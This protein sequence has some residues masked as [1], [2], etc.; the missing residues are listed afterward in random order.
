MGLRYLSVQTLLALMGVA[1]AVLALLP[2]AAA[3]I[4]IA[5]PPIA[6]LISRPGDFQPLP[7]AKPV[8]QV[9]DAES[10]EPVDHE[11]LWARLPLTLRDVSLREMV[12][13]LLVVSYSGT[14]PNA[15]GVGIA[16]DALRRSEIGGVLTFRHN[17]ASGAQTQAINEMF[18]NAH[19]VLPALI[20]VDQEGG[21][22]MRVK[23]S[24]GGPATPS[25]EKIAQGTVA[26][27]EEAYGEMA[28]ALAKLG[29]TV[30]FG[31]VVDL[32]VNPKNPVIARFGRSFGSAPREVVRYASAFIAAHKDAGIAT[33]LKHFP[34]HG[35]SSDD[36]HE[37]ATDLT[38]TWSD[39][40]LIP[41]AELIKQGLADMI[42]M[43]HLKLDGVSGPGDLPASLSPIAIDGVLRSKLC[44]EGLV[45]S[46]DLAMDAIES[47]WGTPEAA[48]LVFEAGGDIVLVSLP[49]GKG[50]TLVR[51]I[52]DHLV[53]KAE[54]D[55]SLAQ[56]IR[57]AYA[58]VVHHKL[59]MASIRKEWRDANAA[60]VLAASLPT[61]AIPRPRPT[62]GRDLAPT[63]GT[64]SEGE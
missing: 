33:S 58:R 42:M 37:S 40:E 3:Q 20:A 7:D 27:A 5:L 12:G 61:A 21:A 19:P 26:E 13:Q 54:Q 62:T 49:A 45:V 4:N 59:A 48:Q 14:S 24:E 16:R 30:N 38:P 8:H 41:F 57:E 2:P 9:V 44:F 47:H 1:I 64:R 55:P 34:G 53:A 10:C 35:S 52:T 56:R 36:S 29:F 28:N 23:P 6:G 63:D 17:I 25:A 22:V 51:E 43:G 50:M 31:P 39:D 60:S 11:V 32:A 46:D 18:L 15:K